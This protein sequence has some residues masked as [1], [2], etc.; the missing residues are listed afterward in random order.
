VKRYARHA[1]PLWARSAATSSTPPDNANEQPTSLTARH[2][3]REQSGSDKRPTAS[4][5]CSAADPIKTLLAAHNRTASVALRVDDLGGC[6]ERVD[7]CCVLDAGAVLVGVG[8][9]W[10]QVPLV[11]D[12]LGGDHPDADV[13]L[14]SFGESP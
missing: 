7:V 2:S 8:E 3:R 10:G 13:V 5:Q 6:G 12:S 4:G 14:E 1:G 11:A 9:W